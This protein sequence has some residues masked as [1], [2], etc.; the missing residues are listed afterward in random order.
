MTTHVGIEPGDGL[1]GRFGDTVIL[2]HRGAGPA[3]DAAEVAGELLDLAAEV[4]SDPERP[5]N[6]IAA[7]LATWVI[8]RM[9][10]DVIAFGI[11]TPVPDGVVMF[12]RGAV[13]CEVTQNGSTRQMS[14]AQALSWV[15]QIIPAPFERLAIGGAPGRPVQ[16]YPRSDLRAGVV[17]GQGFVLTL[18]EAASRREPAASRQESSAGREESSAS[19]EEPSAGRQEPVAN[20]EESAAGRRERAAS[21][22]ESAAGRQE[23]AASRQQ[24]A[25]DQGPAAS[26]EQTA[27]SGSGPA[28]RPAPSPSPAASP[29]PSPAPAESA[30]H[31][32]VDSS[33]PAAPPQPTIIARP[34]PSG[35][36]AAARASAAAPASLGT[37]ASE[38]GPAIPLDRNYV[39]GRDPQHDPLVHSGAADP[40]AIPDAEQMISR[41]H[42]YLSVDNGTVLVRDASS[43]HGTYVRSPG[44]DEWTRLGAEPRALLPGWSLRMGLKVFVFEVS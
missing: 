1:I 9:T 18:L 32:T 10:D 15:D 23:P 4:A 38:R 3:S 34:K 43:A 2:I 26:H 35:R 7:R 36:P 44:S 37:L 16:A 13:C 27:A 39:L 33:G 28:A 42:L 12:L 19:R 6:M 40:V 21:R 5:A 41:V 20:R 31:P 14:G 8:G 29:P 17:P 25:A 30:E 24:T 11:V 22:E